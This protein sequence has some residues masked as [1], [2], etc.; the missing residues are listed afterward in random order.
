MH[1]QTAPKVQGTADDSIIST[2]SKE[3]IITSTK[4]SRENSHAGRRE[5]WKEK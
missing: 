4:E 3:W 2:I 1:Q 5:K